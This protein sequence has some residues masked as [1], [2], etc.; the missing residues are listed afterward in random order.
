MVSP[1]RSRINAFFLWLA[2][3]TYI[4]VTLTGVVILGGLMSIALYI[5]C[6]EAEPTIRWTGMVFQLLGIGTIMEGIREARSPFQGSA[7]PSRFKSWFDRFPFRSRKAYTPPPPE[8]WER[9]MPPTARP[10]ARHE[11]RTDAS[12]P[13]RISALEQSLSSI[14]G[15]LIRTQSN[16]DEHASRSL[17]AL[18]NERHARRIDD[19]DLRATLEQA[20][21]GG[22][23][24]SSVGTV[25]LL[26][27]VVMASTSFE[28]SQLL[29]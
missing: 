18:E 23:Q 20:S 14:E 10:L 24:L 4:W 21:T 2:E 1:V 13:E 22:M 25:W 8:D 28:L 5:D 12:V 17:A 3:P 27:G 7:T 26:I 15:E 19:D 11:P 29:K 16:L 9:P 6:F